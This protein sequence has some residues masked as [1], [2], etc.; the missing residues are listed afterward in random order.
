MTIIKIESEKE[1]LK[2]IVENKL[3]I[4]DFWAEWCGPC[5]VQS[6]IL[7]K[8]AAEYPDDVVVAKVNVDDNEV[9][10]RNYKIASIPT[11]LVFN[12]GVQHGSPIV[13]VVGLERLKNIVFNLRAK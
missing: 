12:N 4:V 7:D 13:G 5:R 3:V 11:T 8:L 1:F 9:L 2:V 6:P 10:A